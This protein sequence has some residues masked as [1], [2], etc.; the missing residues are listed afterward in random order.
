MMYSLLDVNGDWHEFESKQ[1]KR[2]KGATAAAAAAPPPPPPAINNGAKSQ[3]Q[4]DTKISTKRTAVKS[5]SL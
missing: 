4:A 5:G 2:Q 3:K 1:R